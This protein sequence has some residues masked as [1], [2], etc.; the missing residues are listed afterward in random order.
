MLEKNP[1]LAFG[2]SD[3]A[4]MGQSPEE[5]VKLVMMNHGIPPLNKGLVDDL[6][7]LVEEA[8]AKK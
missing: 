5:K 2:T 1:E 8:G 6:V 4:G 7:A 3:P